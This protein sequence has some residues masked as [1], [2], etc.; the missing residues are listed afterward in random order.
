VSAPDGDLLDTHTTQLSG[1][2]TGALLSPAQ[3]VAGL[4]GGG[5]SSPA[6]AGA[7]PSPYLSSPM[8]R[9]GPEVK[10]TGLASAGATP[11]PPPS[12]PRTAT[13]DGDGGGGG[14]LARQPSGFEEASQFDVEGVS[15]EIS[16]WLDAEVFE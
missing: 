15:N 7:S 9:R 2:N 11:C 5:A 4:K 13:T 10:L 12:R 14:G 8:V 3:I 1:E 6:S 16:M